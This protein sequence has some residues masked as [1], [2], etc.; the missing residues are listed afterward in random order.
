[1]ASRWGE[2]DGPLTLFLFPL[3]AAP[4]SGV[5]KQKRREKTD[6][7]YLPDSSNTP[8]LSLPKY[9]LPT[10]LALCPQ[11]PRGEVG[12]HCSA[13]PLR[14]WQCLETFP[15]FFLQN[16]GGGQS[17]A[18]ILS[19]AVSANCPPQPHLFGHLQDPSHTVWAVG[20]PGGGGGGP[21]L[22]PICQASPARSP[23]VCFFMVPRTRNMAASRFPRMQYLLA[24]SHNC[25]A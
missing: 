12:A 21:C 13:A 7:S 1:M 23:T 25:L 14:Q 8:A 24:T 2:F 18:A 5:G 4:I 17:Q 19:T 6:P 15:L 3:L 22:R 11:A 16:T 10:I 9:L 20:T